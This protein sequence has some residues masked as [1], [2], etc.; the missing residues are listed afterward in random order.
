MVVSNNSSARVIGNTIQNNAGVGIQI[1]RDSHA[2]IASNTIN[3]NGDGIEVGE[4]S[5]VQ[6]GEDTGTSIYQSANSGTNAGFGIKCIVGGLADG[7]IGILSGGS[8]AKSFSDPS[9][10]D[11]LSP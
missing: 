3:S 6:L 9:C 1:L 5:L 4:N 8:E 11:S 7:R 2:D 10:T